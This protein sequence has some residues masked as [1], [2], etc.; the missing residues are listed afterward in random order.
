M[1]YWIFDLD[2]TLYNVGKF[3]YKKLDTDYHLIKKLDLLPSKKMIF[4][5]ATMYHTKV[6][7]N[8]LGIMDKFNN[9]YYRDIIGFLKPN[10]NAYNR[11]LLLGNIKKTDK[12]IFFEDTLNN[13]ITAKKLGW[14][15]VYIN[16]N[17]VNHPDVAYSFSSSHVA[18]DYF[19]CV[20]Y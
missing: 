9:I 20:V 12:C 1:L 4:T 17:I 14:V 7:L 15:T 2:H 6:C 5:N 16:P 3:D 10:I 18:L 13:L 19:L 8:K 11:V